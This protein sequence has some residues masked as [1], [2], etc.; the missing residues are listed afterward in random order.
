M[1]FLRMLLLKL[2]VIVHAMVIKLGLGVALHQIFATPQGLLSLPLCGAVRLPHPFFVTT[3]GGLLTT[4]ISVTRLGGIL[5]PSIMHHA[6]GVFKH[7]LPPKLEKVCRIG[8]EFQTVLAV[9]T[10]GIEFV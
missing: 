1:I 3:I 8:V 4:C 9:L 6:L 2:M 10:V 5:F 7:F